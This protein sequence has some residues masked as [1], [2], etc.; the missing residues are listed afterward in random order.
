MFLQKLCTLLFILRL[1]PDLGSKSN[2]VQAQLSYLKKNC[3][4]ETFPNV[5]IILCIYLTWPVAN[6]EGEG[7]FSA[8]KSEKLPVLI[9]DAGL[10]L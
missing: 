8:L 7:S 1:S 9:P 5:A 6:M 10:R 3:F 2:S 4:I